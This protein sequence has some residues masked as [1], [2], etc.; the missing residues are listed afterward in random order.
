MVSVLN[1]VFVVLMKRRRCSCGLFVVSIMCCMSS[2][3]SVL[4][5]VFLFL[6]VSCVSCGVLFGWWFESFELSYYC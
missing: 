4:I 3:S 5:G 2:I 1:C 6:I